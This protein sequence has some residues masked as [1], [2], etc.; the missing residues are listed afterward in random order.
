[1]QKA[2]KVEEVTRLFHQYHNGNMEAR[3]QIIVHNLPFV[4]FLVCKHFKYQLGYDSLD[5][6]I[7]I[8]TIGLIK[9]VDSYKFE[10]NCCFSTYAARVIFNEILMYLKKNK[11]WNYHLSLQQSILDHNDVSL[12]QTISDDFDFVDDIITKLNNEEIYNYL[13]FLSVR[14]QQIIK[15]YFGIGCP[16]LLQLEIAE[17]FQISQSYISRI[18]RRSI[19]KF[20]NISN[21]QSKLKKSPKI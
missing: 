19:I 14:D 17:K 18:I 13:D 3:E 15:L 8:G 12:E 4:T 5:D 6:F 20:Q 9:A 1:M 2:L 7:S 21:S 16:K 11:K 10:K